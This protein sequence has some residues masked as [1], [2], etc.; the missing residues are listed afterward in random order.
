M[1]TATRQH[2]DNE[3][4]DD[5]GNSNDTGVTTT[6]PFQILCLLTIKKN[7]LTII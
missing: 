2:S 4:Y 7:N 6:V 5:N 3:N 1:A